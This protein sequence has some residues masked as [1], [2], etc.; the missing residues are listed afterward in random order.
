MAAIAALVRV[1]RRM[2]YRSSRSSMCSTYRTVVQSGHQ[3]TSL[4]VLG[5][6]TGHSSIVL[7]LRCPPSLLQLLMHVRGPTASARPARLRIQKHIDSHSAQRIWNRR[8]YRSLL[9][10]VTVRSSAGRDI[11]IE[12]TLN[13]YGA[14]ADFFASPPRAESG[15]GRIQC[16]K[17]LC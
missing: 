15:P 7:A 2:R 3:Q 5:S 17:S 8:S 11:D 16:E 1:A 14:V 10:Y 13:E 9:Q 12:W 6:S 4:S